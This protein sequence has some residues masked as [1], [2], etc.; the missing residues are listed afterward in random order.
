MQKIQISVADA[1][2]WCN[3]STIL[4][5]TQLKNIKNGSPQEEPENIYF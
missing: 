1:I 2:A 3:F 4:Q 5:R